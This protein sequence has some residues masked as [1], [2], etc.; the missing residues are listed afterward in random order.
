MKK[1]TYVCESNVTQGAVCPCSQGH[2]EYLHVNN[3]YFQ[4]YSLK[5]ARPI[6][7]KFHVEPS[8]EDRK[9]IYNGPGHVTKMAAMI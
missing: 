8:K 7:A 2:Y 5:T 4:I 1:T 3:H 9:Y 6:K